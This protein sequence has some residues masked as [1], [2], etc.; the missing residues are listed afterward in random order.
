MRCGEGPLRRVA[1][2]PALAFET[3]F[4]ERQSAQTRAR[5]FA[6]SFAMSIEL[7]SGDFDEP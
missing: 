5:S 1:P 3:A 4:A 6:I 2:D 7:C